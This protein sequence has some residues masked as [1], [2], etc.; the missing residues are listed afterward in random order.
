M[1]KSQSTL[2]PK[3][4]SAQ[5]LGTPEHP[6]IKSPDQMVE[7]ISH[8]GT[9]GNFLKR[10]AGHLQELSTMLYELQDRGDTEREYARSI[11]IGVETLLDAYANDV[12]EVADGIIELS[13][14]ARAIREERKGGEV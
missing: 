8:L 6:P 12:E 4:V 3:L 13:K 11:I 2:K 1:A 7:T 10:T 9:S 14:D 5:K